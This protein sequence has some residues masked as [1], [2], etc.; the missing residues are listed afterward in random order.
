LENAPLGDTSLTAIIFFGD[1]DFCRSDL[2]A[3]AVKEI[4]KV[5]DCQIIVVGN[6]PKD[7]QIAQQYGP[8]VIA[9]AIGNHT[10]SQV[11][12]YTPSLTVKNFEQGLN[13]TTNFLKHIIS[14]QL[15][16]SKPKT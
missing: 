16:N 12:R 14:T 3:R 5:N 6:T 10:L 15:F 9:V 2:V 13:A 7:I 4:Y 8:P 1:L 11:A